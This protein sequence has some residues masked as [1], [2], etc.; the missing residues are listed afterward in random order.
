M[1]PDKNRTEDILAE[2]LAKPVET[3]IQCL[4]VILDA[5]DR[6]HGLLASESKQ[7][8]LQRP[9]VFC[10]AVHRVGATA[11]H[12]GQTRALEE[13]CVL[14]ARSRLPVPL[15]QRERHLLT[16]PRST[17]KCRFRTQ[18]VT[19]PLLGRRSL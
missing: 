18:P 8:G 14:V 19:L 5:A 7:C 17:V 11:H 9:L 2:P 16:P 10:E 4:V 15:I 12:R 6:S 3:A 13:W 1:F